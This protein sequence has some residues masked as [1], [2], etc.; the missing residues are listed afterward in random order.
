MTE[1]A[2]SPDRLPAS[3]ASEVLAG[4]VTWQDY[5]DLVGSRVLILPVG[6]T[7]QHGPHL[8]IGTD[9]ITVAEVG[10]RVAAETGS[11]VLPAMPYGYR[12]N[13]QTGGGETFPGTTS[14]SG[15]TLTLN[16]KDVLAAAIS[17]GA[18]RLVVLNGHYENAP[19]LDEGIRIALK[20]PGV[21][22][23][24]VLQLLWADGISDD[25]IAECW[26]GGF[27]GW[28][29]EHAAHLETSVMLAIHPELVHLDRAPTAEQFTPRPYQVF[30]ESLVPVPSHGALSSSDLASAA[31]GERIVASC[32]AGIAQILRKEF[33]DAVT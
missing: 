8:P 3:P 18:R 9:C 13:P 20:T 26:P 33:P 15:Q 31:I 21:E 19:F 2:A 25:V 11:L 23:A 14:L 32:V 16:I 28:G 10:R 24:K 4:Q 17:D 1:T 30:P 12:S 6:S 5:R 29:L 7:E 27:P 22:S